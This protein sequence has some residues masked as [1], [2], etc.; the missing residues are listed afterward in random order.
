M[1][2]KPQYKWFLLI[3]L[4]SISCCA[5]AQ[6]KLDSTI[7]SDSLKKDLV[8][9]LEDLGRREL[10]KK[11]ESFKKDQITVAQHKVLAEIQILTIHAKD[12]LKNGIDTTGIKV[13]IDN[14]DKW[15]EIAGDGVFR[16]RGSTQTHRN[17]VTSYKIIH[18]LRM[19]ATSKQNQVNRYYKELMNYRLRL[20][21]LTSDSILYDFSTDTI[22]A[23]EYTKQLISAA[24]EL[25]PTDSILK[26]AIPRLRALQRRIEAVVSTMNSGLEEI[27]RYQASVYDNSLNREVANLWSPVQ[28]SRPFGDIVQFSK[29][30][31]ILGL[32]FYM[33]NN[34]GRLILLVLL[35]IGGTL[36]LKSLKRKVVAEEIPGSYKNGNLLLR[37]PLLSAS[38]IILNIFQFI[39]NDPPFLFNFLLWI[40][41]IFCL[42]VIFRGFISKYWM[43]V[44]LSIVLIFLVAC[45]NNL[46]LQASRPGRWIMVSIA[47]AGILVC[48]I[49]L[50][51]GR[52][53]E[54]RERSII[55]F[56]AFVIFLELASLLL[57][58]SGRYNLSKSLL[59]SGYVNIVV[60]V[61][62]IWTVRLIDE[63]LRLAN[64]V[65]KKPDRNS[66]Y[67]NFERVGKKV[68]RIFYVLILFGWL[69]IFGRN[70]YA[71]KFITEPLSDFLYD[72]RKVGEF[73][74]AVHN[75]LLFFLILVISV[76]LS[77][78]VSFFASDDN[79][80]QHSSAEKKP[81]IGSWVLLIRIL[82]IT[83]GIFLAMAAAGIPM[84]KAAIVIGA[85]GVGIGLGLQS[86]VNNLVSGLI[87]AFEKPVNVGDIIEISGKSGVIRTIGF[88]SS[89][90]NTWDGSDVIIP[91]GDLL[92]AHLVN[93]TRGNTV[94]RVEIALGIAIGSDLDKIKELITKLFSTNERVLKDPPPFVVANDFTN[95]SLN[96]SIYFW[97]SH[98]R[99]WKALR[100]EFIVAI[101]KLLKENAIV[102]AIPQQDITL[103][104]EPTSPGADNK[105]EE[106]K[107]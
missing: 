17:L 100:S 3:A 19:R 23:R 57:N 56:I 75:I 63:G 80:W 42:T 105:N 73:T 20:D 92:N 48:V 47:L 94:R 82:I 77:K 64:Q 90:V 93:W 4:F 29:A 104:N 24:Q 13:D 67:I 36:F 89:V 81:G 85:L 54:L 103:S 44:W 83:M 45:A 35:I 30:K 10:K 39:F 87:I 65:Y 88:R 95:N 37:H 99:E 84:D 71:F 66:L 28:F 18:E 58:I 53:G 107:I 98:T 46:I 2:L 78:L 25:V 33:T 60:G 91:N 16:N 51:R 59:V 38:F 72:E 14:L 32:V 27:E 15:Y 61:L 97:V 70:F 101:N 86:L 68:P 41:S 106:K 76:M 22:E 1:D 62:L 6:E 11:V 34:M 69:V 7:T 40:V 102:F 74:F 79:A 43:Q 12:Y 8:T 9:T 50:I 5:T 55:F 96:I 31:T 26:T 49:T 52:R 21:S